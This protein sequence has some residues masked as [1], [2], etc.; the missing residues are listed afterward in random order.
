MW[1]IDTPFSGIII[2]SIDVERGHASKNL[3]S[4]TAQ[5]I[6][7][8][9]AVM[10][11]FVL[12]PRQQARHEPRQQGIHQEET[13]PN[14]KAGGSYSNR[15]TYGSRP[16]KNPALRAQYDHN[17]KIILST[18]SVCGICGKPVDKSL[19]YPDPMSPTVDHIIP[20]SKH[21]DP[22]SLDNLQLAHRYCNR[23]KSDKLPQ[24]EVSKTNAELNALPQSRNW[25][26]D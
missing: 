18:Q 3:L 8:R 6:Q 4:K 5:T 26:T 13:M 7:Q 15:P 12:Q 23:M 19:R 24:E 22:I 1:K 17:K 25:R 16:D 11:A 21:G 2:V 10:L 14:K 9:P 20:V